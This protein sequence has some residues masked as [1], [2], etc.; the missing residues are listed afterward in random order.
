M[1]DGCV[2][3][4][5]RVL[6]LCQQPIEQHIMLHAVTLPHGQPRTL[7]F[8]HHRPR[9]THTSDPAQQRIIST[10]LTQLNTSPGH[11]P[12]TNRTSTS[13]TENTASIITQP[14]SNR[15]AGLGLAGPALGHRHQQVGACPVVHVLLRCAPARLRLLL[16]Q[17]HTAHKAQQQ[18]D[19][20]GA[21]H[22]REL[23]APQATSTEGEHAP[24]AA[25]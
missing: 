8:P 9:R 14:P 11:Q 3:G 15:S 24:P 12:R 17:R 25:V 2:M 7:Q 20:Q 10:P 13:P 6:F 16:L 18:H 1:C 4:F 19:K 22:T 5:R 21:G 23:G